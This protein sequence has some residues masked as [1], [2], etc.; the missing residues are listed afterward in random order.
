MLRVISLSSLASR[1]ADAE[2]A[3]LDLD[4]ERLDLAAIAA[5]ELVADLAVELDLDR[6]RLRGPDERGAV[7][8]ADGRAGERPRPLRPAPRRSRCRAR[9][10]RR[11]AARRGTG[12][13]RRTRRRGCR[14]GRRSTRPSYQSA[15]STSISASNAFARRLR[16]PLHRYA[17]RPTRSLRSSASRIIAASNP[18]PAITAKRSLLEAADVDAA[19]GRR[20][21]R[22]RRRPRCPSGC[23]RFVA[24]RFAVP[25]GT[26]A[27]L[28]SGAGE[29][30][31]AP[32]HRAVAAPGEHEVG[33][34]VQRAADLLGR[35]LRL[36]H[37]V[38]QRVVD[39]RGRQAR[40][41][42]RAARRRAASRRGR[43]PRRSC[44][45]LRAACGVAAGAVCGLR[46]AC[47]TPAARQANSSTSSAPMPTTS[48]PATSSGWCMPRYIR[49]SATITGSRSG[50]RP[51]DARATA[52]AGTAT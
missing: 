40:G 29:L 35:L 37:L 33:A 49:E 16:E 36:R 17:A 20:G 3:G 22:R 7:R 8:V 42:A 47:A 5:V 39:A 25:A 44:H 2:G 24:N 26:T 45:R 11:R 10:R 30:A 52:R 9:A 19:G 14:A 48:P 18:A 23:P 4:L 1:D 50:D 51:G 31:D 41:A 43:R 38:P 27:R 13:R 46:A 32:A 12:R 6:L 15:P 34:L 21:A 28:A